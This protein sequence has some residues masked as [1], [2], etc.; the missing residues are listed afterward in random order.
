MNKEERN[1]KIL[2]IVIV[3]SVLAV[4]VYNLFFSKDKIEEEKIDTKTISVV[5]DNSKFYT[6]SSCVSKYL[7]YL[8]ISDT[9]KLLILLSNDFKT[10]N[11]VNSSNIYNFISNNSSTNFSP[12]KIFEQR[13]TKTIYK[14]YVKGYTEEETIYSSSNKQDFYIIVILDEKNMTF[15]IEP[16]DGSMF[17]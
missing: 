1:K 17:K 7:N 8:A 13:L 9:D 12:V 14:Y 5:Q 3:I 6:V 4:G 15:E 2:A 16:Y 11:S 10:K